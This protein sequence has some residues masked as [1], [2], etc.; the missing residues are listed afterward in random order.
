MS[1][2]SNENGNFPNENLEKELKFFN[3]TIGRKKELNLNNPTDR[4]LII[5]GLIF[6]DDPDHIFEEKLE[7]IKNFTNTDS[8]VDNLFNLY[9]FTYHDEKDEVKKIIN[10]IK[11]IKEKKIFNSAFE[12]ALLN[13]NSE[14]IEL[15]L[16]LIT[17]YEDKEYFFNFTIFHYKYSS[18]LTLIDNNFQVNKVD[19]NVLR[20]LFRVY[21]K[22]LGT[23][24][25]IKVIENI[26]N[27][28]FSNKEIL[29]N[30]LNNPNFKGYMINYKNYKLFE[31]VIDQINNNRII[32]VIRVFV[33]LEPQ[34]EFLKNYENKV[35]LREL[36]DLY[37][38]G[39]A[40]TLNSKLL[41]K[42]ELYD[43][44]KK[45]NLDE[46]WNSDEKD[47]TFLF[48]DK[49]MK[50][51]FR[52]IPKTTEEITVYR[53]I[54][55]NGELK[56][57][58]YISTSINE[59]IAKD[60]IYEERNKSILK[61][62]V[63]KGSSVIPLYLFS[64]YDTENEVLLDKDTELKCFKTDYENDYEIFNCSMFGKK[65]NKKLSKKFSKKF[66]KKKSKNYR[67]RN[68]KTIEKTFLK[69]ISQSHKSR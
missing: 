42:E 28:L 45:V 51:L 54:S 34:C 67:K 39:P 41:N 63:P 1:F 36:I 69:K 27:L 23:K 11:K 13:E 12:L 64:S 19:F 65:S 47:E 62:I 26:I 2:H 30:Y 4:K 15:F 59:E 40:R 57:G 61:I 18:L 29:N 31:K 60:I 21:D 8:D 35:L 46:Y 38:T 9:Y 52:F 44:S 14:I 43:F 22:K 58:N 7:Q 20:D 68:Q 32:E 50:H 53:G 37:T 33:V 49:G 3:D 6:G 16:K 55:L 48:I 24:D 66:S 56:H 17:K 25:E 5:N 10:N